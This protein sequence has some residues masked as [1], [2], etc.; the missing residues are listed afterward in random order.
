MIKRLVA[1]GV[2]AGILPGCA[3]DAEWLHRQPA[4]ES[5]LGRDPNKM[6]AGKVISPAGMGVDLSE[7]SPPPGTVAWA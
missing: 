5:T 4:V 2:L 7:G 3:H 6:P 1:L